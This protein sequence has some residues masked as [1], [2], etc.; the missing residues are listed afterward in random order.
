MKVRTCGGTFALAMLVVLSTASVAGPLVFGNPTSSPLADE[1]PSSDELY[2]FSDSS[3]DDVGSSG[4]P[5]AGPALARAQG[6]DVTLD[7]QN[8]PAHPVPEPHSVWLLG[9]SMLG[10]AGFRMIRQRRV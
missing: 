8:P 7:A 6:G 2:G 9:S 5:D 3:F 10:L 1:S 4:F